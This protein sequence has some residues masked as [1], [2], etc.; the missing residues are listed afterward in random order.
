MTNELRDEDHLLARNL[1]RQDKDAS[2]GSVDSGTVGE[3]AGF[4]SSGVGALYDAR[5]SE[6][7]A[8][9]QALKT[10][11]SITICGVAPRPLVEAMQRLARQAIATENPL[12]WQQ[13]TYITPSSNLI[14]S[15]Q[16]RTQLGSVAQE[17][18]AGLRGIRDCVRESTRDPTSASPGSPSLR[19]TLLGTTEL[20]LEV[21]LLTRDQETEREHAW[22]S[23]GPV[24][25]REETPYL[26]FDEDT[27]F[28]HRITAAVSQLS[29][30]STPLV[31]RQ[32]DISLDGLEEATGNCEPPEIPSLEI[33]SLQPFGTPPSVPSC[34]P[35]AITVLRSAAAGRPIVLLKRRTPF[36]DADDFD[37]LSLLSARLLE[38]DLAGALGVSTYPDREP[39]AA[40][41]A[42][43]KSHGGSL[44]PLAV[45]LQTFLRAAQ[46]DVFATCGLDLPA[47]RFTYRGCQLVERE[48]Q[49]Q[50]LFF[51]VFEVVLFRSRY[52]DEVELAEAWN[53]QQLERVYED[54]LY[55]SSYRR[56]LNRLLI[57]RE[58]W[59]QQVIFSH[60][61]EHLHRPP[62][63]DDRLHRFYLE[64]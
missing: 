12:P 55:R 22:V 3:R 10:A 39:G 53:P 18:Q 37:K 59:L 62:R 50:F 8:L 54:V 29:G 16:G 35:T 36:T 44:A 4:I 38:E 2:P 13:I 42:M 48:Q 17:W 5:P 49:S 9:E 15:Y 20:F 40:L 31:S 52:E 51:C 63:D 64:S 60:P 7:K 47:N 30:L 23:V 1:N 24:L 58:D 43:W 27:E 21:V 57:Q 41:D 33:R 46:R 6:R 34:L 32:L 14:F 28:F 61:I 26:V 11:F 45:P 25:A 56:E 19:L